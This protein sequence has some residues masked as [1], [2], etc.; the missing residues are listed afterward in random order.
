MLRNYTN[1]KTTKHL[2]SS[3][4]YSWKRTVFIFYFSLL[5]VR[6]FS[7]TIY[8]EAARKF[9]LPFPASVYDSVEYTTKLK[10]HSKVEG[11]YCFNCEY[12]NRRFYK[13]GAVDI[14]IEDLEL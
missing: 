10:K 1:P 4:F 12:K 13:N 2:M 8:E 3:K 11:M 14:M 7:T 9:T 5:I 6:V